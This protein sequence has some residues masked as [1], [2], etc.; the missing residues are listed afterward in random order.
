MSKETEKLTKKLVDLKMAYRELEAETS[1]EIQKLKAENMKLLKQANLRN[2]SKER[3]EKQKE[4]LRLYASG[5]AP[6]NI[7]QILTSE[8]GIAITLEETQLIVDKVEMLPPEMY[9]FYLASKKDF[10][11]KITI[12][13][14]FFKSAIYKKF[15]LLETVQSAG[16]ARARE[17]GD[18]ALILKYSDQLMKLYEK[19]S[20]TF[21]KNGVELAADRTVEEL[22]ADFGVDDTEKEKSIIRFKAK[23]V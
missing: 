14:G 3:I 11:E 21:F 10:K 17:I 13:G 16:L 1:K 9:R 4:V 15:T 2:P 5:Y 7:Y 23:V 12:D 19:M 8:K 6:G 20:N 22:M 18:D